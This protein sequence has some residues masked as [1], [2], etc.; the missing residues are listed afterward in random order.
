MSDKKYPIGTMVKYLGEVDPN[1]AAQKDIGKAGKIVGW[2]NG[3]YP[4]IFL[5]NSTHISRYSTMKVAASWGC[6]W[7]ALEILLQKNQQ[8]LFAFMD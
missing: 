6:S 1:D 8:L 4:V 3:N 7:Y 5:P 2:H